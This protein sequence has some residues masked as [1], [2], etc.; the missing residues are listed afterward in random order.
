[1]YK[2]IFSNSLIM[3]SLLMYLGCS[4]DFIPN[5]IPDGADAPSGE[6]VQ[7]YFNSEV[8]SVLTTCVSCHS[9][10]GSAKGTNLVFKEPIASSKNENFAILKTYIEAEGD[11]V[12]TKGANEEAHNGGTQLS[13][14]SKVAMQLFV[15]YVNGKQ[16]CSS[17]SVKSSIA[18]SQV[19]VL[20][21]EATLR[22][23]AFKLTGNAP[24]EVELASVKSIDDL[25]PI[26][27]DYM[28]TEG[29]KSWLKES[30]NDFLLTDFY[31][32]RRENA[33]D[34]LNDE[35]FPSRRWY[36]DLESI[37][38]STIRANTNYAIAR[39][40]INLMLHVI[41]NNRP[42]SEILTADYVLVNPYSARVYDADI[43]G[44]TFDVGDFNLTEEAM[45]AK[46]DREAL[47]EVKLPNIP[48]AGL[49]STIA[50]LNRFPSTPTNLDRHRSAKVQLFFLDTDILGLANRPINSSEVVSDSA[51]W[52][53]PNCTIC[54][55]IMEPIASTFKNWDEEGRY[56]AGF[57]GDA[58]QV[59]GMSIEKRAPND[60]S[61]HL[62]QWLAG[63][64]T[65]D[66]RFAVSSVKMFLKALTGRDAMKEPE[67]DAD[68]YLTKLQ[69][70]NFENKFITF[71]KEK[72]IASNYN[73]KMIIK[74]IIKSP[75]YRATGFDNGVDN[76]ILS[77]HLG[78]AH[79]ITPE[80]LNRKIYSVMGYYWSSRRYDTNQ[81]ENNNSSDHRLLDEFKTLY[82]GMD[83]VNITSRK[84]DLNGIMANIQTRMA[85]QMGCFPTTRDFY[86][87]PDKRKLFPYV[88]KDLKPL[89][90]Y[91]IE[92]IKKNIQYLHSHILGESL[93]I[94]D[95]EIEATYKLFL[96]TY[97]DGRVAVLSGDESEYLL[98]ECRLDVA[99]DESALEPSKQIRKDEYYVIRSWSAV[100]TY[101]LSDFK[102]VYENNVE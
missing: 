55:N 86:F 76:A 62:L 43:N 72:F 98:N 94:D 81:N 57:R 18:T 32:D 37:S 99:P 79:L 22:S 53:N 28:E 58:V 38:E 66:D 100:I 90:A 8:S 73:A 63:E 20:S 54:H 84:D 89:D 41:E 2:V 60:A 51:T 35:D 15:N 3:A 95:P 80:A 36:T 101:L 1:M 97:T 85:L 75:L 48:H 17:A 102:F 13:G 77:S 26:L 31:L 68:D 65:K 34:L 19:H 10:K 7:D 39:E 83:S 74:E 33:E 21:A 23:A 70:Y 49:L 30:F 24:T 71:T 11:K 56:I 44:F 5:G 6:C 12:V 92:K 25:D 61:E 96:D 9:D 52:T 87:A 16:E 47:R 82:G 67:A 50:F 27:Y 29:F 93:P 91:S 69:A 46:Y 45:E 4:S 40:P 42:Y 64:I 88:T 78:Q 14:N 59:P